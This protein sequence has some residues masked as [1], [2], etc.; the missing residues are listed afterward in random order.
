MRGPR[1][2][3]LY[4]ME[5]EGYHKIGIANDHKYRVKELQTGNPFKITLLGCIPCYDAVKEE[6]YLQQRL[7]AY[8]HR[9]EWFKL[10]ETEVAYLLQHLS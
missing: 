7:R 6:F 10:P 5:C 4:V 3:Y 2:G 1:K 9:S 8:K